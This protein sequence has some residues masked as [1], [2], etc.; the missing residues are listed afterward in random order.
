MERESAKQRNDFFLT[1]PSRLSQR[2]TKKP[3]NRRWGDSTGFER[4]LSGSSAPPPTRR[5]FP[6]A[7]A[8]HALSRVLAP[9]SASLARATLFARCSCTRCSGTRPLVAPL[10]TR[11]SGAL[12]ARPLAVAACARCSGTR[13]LVAPLSTRC[14]GALYARPLAAA[15]CARC[16]CVRCCCSRSTIPTAVS[17]VCW[18]A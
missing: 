16:S 1:K 2:G 13:P 5:Y 17:A 12:C 4:S 6:Q 18:C 11:C 14:Y 8:R 3:P 10:S 7:C 9:A 15:A